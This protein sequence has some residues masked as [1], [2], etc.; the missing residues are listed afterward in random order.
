MDWKCTF[1]VDILWN[2]TNKTNV[3]LE[4]ITWVSDG[5]FIMI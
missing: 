2:L 5:D 3:F 1:N 4:F